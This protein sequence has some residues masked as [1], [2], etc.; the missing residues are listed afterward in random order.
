MPRRLLLPPSVAAT[1]ACLLAAPA[2]VR[3]RLHA[4]VG[5]VAERGRHRHALQARALHRDRDLPARLGHAGLVAGE[6]PRPPRRQSRPDPR[7]HAARVGWTVGAA[8]ILVVLTVV[9]FLYL[10]RSRTRR[11][12]PERPERGRRRSSPSVDQP[13]PAE[14]GG[15]ILRIH[16]NGQQ[17]IWRYDYPGDKQLFSYRRWWCPRTRPSCSRSRPPT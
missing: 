9:T 5:R 17:Y 7:Q 14:G 10:D 4:R 11:L 12:R 8:S 16:V 15:P 1:L 13:E 6:V 2:R 3:G